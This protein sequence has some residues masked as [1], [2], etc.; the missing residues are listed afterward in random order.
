MFTPLGENTHKIFIFI[1][2]IFA[3]S[4]SSFFLSLSLLSLSFSRGPLLLG[5]KHVFIFFLLF[6][7]PALSHAH[8]FLSYVEF[9]LATEFFLFK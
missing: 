7:S 2:I 9:I 5:S 4:L 8:S 6:L 3:F 1:L